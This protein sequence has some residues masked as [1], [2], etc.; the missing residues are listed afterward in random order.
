M[1]DFRAEAPDTWLETLVSLGKT[2]EPMI[3][4]FL[5]GSPAGDSEPNEFT[6]PVFLPALCSS[7][8]IA[9]IVVC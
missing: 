8:L 6:S 5:S 4:P 3:A 2:L 1:S 9:L 7:F